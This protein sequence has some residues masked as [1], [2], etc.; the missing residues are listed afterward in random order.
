MAVL[1]DSINPNVRRK[2]QIG[3]QGVIG[4]QHRDFGRLR[5]L[6]LHDQVCAVEHRGGVLQNAR[7]GCFI[8]IVGETNTQPRTR[9]DKH[10]MAV[11]DQFVHPFWRQADPK[12]ACFDFPN[13]PDAQG[14]TPRDGRRRLT[15]E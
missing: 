14:L 7:S 8:H 9:F 6:D 15:P 11:R 1:P 12:F 2:M 5:L 3:E 13:C 4:A 10:L